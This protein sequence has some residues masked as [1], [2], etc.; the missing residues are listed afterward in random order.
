M[1]L[2]VALIEGVKGYY[3]GE[4]SIEAVTRALGNDPQTIPTLLAEIAKAQQNQRNA[5]GIKYSERVITL[6]ETLTCMMSAS[7]L[8]NG[9]FSSE[10]VKEPVTKREA[11]SCLFAKATSALTKESFEACRDL[12]GPVEISVANVHA[13][14]L[15][16]IQNATDVLGPIQKVALLYTDFEKD[17]LIAFIEKFPQ[18][19]QIQLSQS[20]E[21]TDEVLEEANLPKT[22]EEIDLWGTSVSAKGLSTLF[23]KCPAL[24]RVNV[25]NCENIDHLELAGLVCPDSLTDIVCDSFWV[26]GKNFEELE[27]AAK[28][29]SNSPLA[30]LLYA[31]ALLESSRADKSEAVHLLEQIFTARPSFIPTALL[32]IDLLQ[33]GHSNLEANLLKAKGALIRLEQTD[34]ICTPRMLCI[35]AL[36]TRNFDL[37]YEAYKKEPHDEFVTSV[38]SELA[39]EQDNVP[40]AA[41]LARRTLRTNERNARAHLTAAALTRRD[42]CDIAEDH[43]RTALSINPHN[44]QALF[45]LATLIQDTRPD[46][47][48]PLLL[49]SLSL[50]KTADANFALAKLYAR[51]NDLENAKASFE[52]ALK[53]DPYNA[54]IQYHYGEF[55][56][57]THPDPEGRKKAIGL[58]SAA[59]EPQ[60]KKKRITYDDAHASLAALQLEELSGTFANTNEALKHAE[61]A[62]AKNP[63]DPFVRSILGEL[64]LLIDE[65][66]AVAYLED[67]VYSQDEID[68]SAAVAL[69]THFI[70]S[71]DEKAEKYFELLEAHAED[72]V[73]LA[74]AKARRHIWNLKFDAAEEV[75]KDLKQD[76]EVLVLQTEIHFAKGDKEATSKA[77]QTISQQHGKNLSHA[78]TVDLI[79]LLALYPNFLE[80]SKKWIER[81]A[82]K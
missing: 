43:Y 57:M 37:A 22:L 29:N 44:K 72:D 60:E 19:K 47:A 46:D 61:L 4:Y 45:G 3:K 65:E 23:E 18:A 58:L 9:H 68:I 40:L 41:F 5:L 2:P 63:K 79:T 39:L 51:K 82:A 52:D 78:L 59:C 55:L 14:L 81:L 20:L 75:L 34:P 16:S 7:R 74:L 53:L 25:A 80:D 71:D 24:K 76:V 64:L 49:T 33:T 13:E 31:S 50:E 35:K 56:R 17:A 6:T 12:E 28:K 38:L 66:R 30:C 67:L 32:Y 27:A 26:T 62:F 42:S 70:E 69:A 8:A 15:T 21:L 1:S 10:L 77:L 73:R 48:I 54:Q 36:N 11:L